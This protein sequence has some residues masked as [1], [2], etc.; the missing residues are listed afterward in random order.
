MCSDSR[1]L[2]GFAP[3]KVEDDLRDESAQIDTAACGQRSWMP[4]GVALEQFAAALA[5]HSVLGTRRARA[6]NFARSARGLDRSGTFR[7]GADTAKKPGNR[8]AVCWNWGPAESH[9]TRS[10][11]WGP[12]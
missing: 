4:A 9:G 5:D 6:M 12:R 3:R 10:D 11:C 1:F 2:D 8:H 7:S